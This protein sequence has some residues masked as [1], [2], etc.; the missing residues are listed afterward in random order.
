M[1]IGV[2]RSR[3]ALGLLILGALGVGRPA[4]AQIDLS[5]EWGGIFHEDLPAALMRVPTRLRV[6]WEDDATLRIDTDAGQQTRLLRFK[7]RAPAGSSRPRDEPADRPSPAARTWQGASAAEWEQIASP[8][9]LGVSLQ[10]APPRI[11]SLKV[12]TTNLRPGYLRKN[13]VPYS[14]DTV[15]TEYFDRVSA[16][17]DDWL[18]VIAIVDDPRYLNQPF[19]TSSHFKREPDGSRWM[20][21]PCGPPAHPAR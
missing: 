20:P 12:V 19:I 13:G 17:G 2:R 1:I 5:G 3:I 7:R 9:G 6:T 18:T 10:Q 11:G 15:L 8:G 21:A 14:E 4:S 16:F